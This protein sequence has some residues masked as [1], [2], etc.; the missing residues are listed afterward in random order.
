[1]LH[2]SIHQNRVG[3]LLGNAL[4]TFLI[5]VLFD[6]R[7]TDLGPFRAVRFDRL[8]EMDMQEKT[9]GWTVGMQVKAAEMG[10]RVCEVPVSYRRRIGKSKISGTI[11]GTIKAGYVILATIFRH[12]LG[13]H[14]QRAARRP[15]ESR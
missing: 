7:Y 1:M 3:A 12:G 15:P 4:A 8:R 11:Q 9:F 10:I 14:S 13:R 6:V 5:R 2:F